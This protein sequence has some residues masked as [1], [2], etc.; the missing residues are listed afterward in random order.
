MEQTQNKTALKDIKANVIVIAIAV[1]SLIIV[2]I[3]KNIA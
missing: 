2:A 1:V 3:A